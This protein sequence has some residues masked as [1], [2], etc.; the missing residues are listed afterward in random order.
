ME[1]IKFEV[2]APAVRTW[3]GSIGEMV[4]VLYLKKRFETVEPYSRLARHFILASR[5][6][7]RG[8]IGRGRSLF[9][10]AT[11]FA[12]RPPKNVLRVFNGGLPDFVSYHCNPPKKVANRNRLYCMDCPQCERDQFGQPNNCNKVRFVEFYDAK[13]HTKKFQPSLTLSQKKLREKARRAGIPFYL[14]GVNISNFPKL[15]F[16]LTLKHIA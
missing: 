11:V 7:G 6:V 13:T 3:G 12:Y 8:I 14:I 2:P 15:E 10:G 4:A 5:K 9:Y 1:I 16:K